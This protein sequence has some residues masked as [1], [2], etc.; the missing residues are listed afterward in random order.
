L[1]NPL[2]ITSISTI[3][4][5][6]FNPKN[7][8]ENYQNSNHFF[9][10][11]PE[12]KN[13]FGAKI[14]FSNEELIN[15]L[16]LSEKKIEKLDR[17]VLMALF[18]A[19][20]MG[21]L[22]DLKGEKIG[23]NISSSRGA[24]ELWE[25]YHAQSL[26]NEKF[27]LLSSPTTSLGNISSWVGQFL[28]SNGIQFSHSMTCSSSLI[29]ILNSIAWINSGMSE[30]MLVGG[31]EAPLTPFTINQMN[32]LKIYSQLNDE[33]PCKAGKLGKSE[34]TMILGEAA[35]LCLIEKNP[36][37]KPLA[38][39]KGFGFGSEMLKNPVSLSPKAENLQIA[40]NQ[41]V[42]NFPKEEID[43]I[44]SHTP[45]TIKGDEAEFNA[46]HSV[47]KDK[48]PYILNN[49]WKIGHTFGASGIMSLE[50][51]LMILKHQKL[52]NYPFSNQEKPKEI[53]NILI[54]SMGFGGNAISILVGI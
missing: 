36:T 26:N 5:L 37:S 28:N 12:L 15:Q 11:I 41:I 4:S 24:T 18:C 47:F 3:S 53:R 48:I 9:E 27:S 25:N 31:S 54:N 30:I 23:V 33:F 22:K 46:I 42:D 40:L 38:F 19:S 51:A 6:G 13:N 49:K 7:I 20:K 1:K 16:Q 43:V 45:G 10:K 35:G 52:I 14:A 29:S 39:I 21:N 34:N 2:T 17:T 32:A 44:I 50:L 8:W